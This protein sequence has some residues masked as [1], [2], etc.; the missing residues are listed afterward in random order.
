MKVTWPTLNSQSLPFFHM[1]VLTCTPLVRAD[2]ADENHTPTHSLAQLVHQ[3]LH[4]DLQ[5]RPSFDCNYINS[6]VVLFCTDTMSSPR[7]CLCLCKSLALSGFL[8]PH[9]LTLGTCAFFYNNNKRLYMFT[10]ILQ[11]L[12]ENLSRILLSPLYAM[13]F[14][15]CHM[16]GVWVQSFVKTYLLSLSR[17]P[18]Q[19][20]VDALMIRHT[21]RVYIRH[22]P[23]L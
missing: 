18:M 21:P 16:Y 1:R 9:L 17:L 19:G 10:H 11:Y 13:C 3:K 6:R 20:N 14:L 23:R 5:T 22:T 12:G 15:L 2:S 4:P 7:L 8:C